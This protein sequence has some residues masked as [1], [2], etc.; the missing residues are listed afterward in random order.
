MLLHKSP[1]SSWLNAMTELFSHFLH[2]PITYSLG[3]TITSIS[4][5]YCSFLDKRPPFLICYKNGFINSEKSDLQDLQK[6]EATVSKSK[7]LQNY[8]K[9]LFQHEN[10][11]SLFIIELMSNIFGFLRLSHREYTLAWFVRGQPLIKNG[12]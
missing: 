11:S 3:V 10:C 6:Q 1:G 8:K 9:H 2:H 7:T 12:H 5:V 4:V